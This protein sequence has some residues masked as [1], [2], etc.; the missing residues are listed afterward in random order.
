MVNNKQLGEIMNKLMVCGLLISQ[1][2]AANI[3]A[4]TVIWNMF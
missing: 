1:M 2:G 4:Y 3:V